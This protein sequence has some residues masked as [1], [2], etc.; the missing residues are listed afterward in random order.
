MARRALA[1]SP[2]VSAVWMAASMQMMVLSLRVARL[3]VEVEVDL[4]GRLLVR[5]LRGLRAEGGRLVVMT[6]ARPLAVALPAA[7][8]SLF[9]TD[10]VRLRDDRPASSS[11][12]S[13]S[14]QR[15]LT[16]LARRRGSVAYM[17][18][19][20]LLSRVNI[21]LPL[22]LPASSLV[23]SFTRLR[24]PR[25]PYL[26]AGAAGAAAGSFLRV[27]AAPGRASPSGFFLRPS[28]LL[29]DSSFRSVFL[30]RAW[31]WA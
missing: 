21:P 24:R 29:R 16:S 13:C 4:A 6:E 15:A 3:E 7:A 20:F 22:S 14:R 1:T 18:S 28:V 10:L 27:G 12:A 25:L 8:A 11:A 5:G 19:V 31:V 17:S 23:V 2:P 30:V 9:P 26:S